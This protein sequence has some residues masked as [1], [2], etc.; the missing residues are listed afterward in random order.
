MRACLLL[1]VALAVAGTCRAGASIID[2]LRVPSGFHVA[3]YSDDVADAREM[4]LG[5]D[6]TVYVGSSRAGRIYALTDADHDGRAERVRVIASGL[7]DPIGVAFH[8]G[9][10]YASAVSRILVWRDIGQHLDQP[11][12]P[13]V[14]TGRLPDEGHHGGRFIAFGPDGKL[15]VPIGAPCNICKRK[16]YARLLRM[17]AH[18]TH[19][20][21]VAR[22]IRNTV[23]F[24]WQPGSQRLW[25]TDNGRD[26]LGDNVPSDELNRVDHVG[27]NFGYP[28]CHAGDVLDPKFGDDLSC[29][30]FAAPALKLGA[31]VAAL[32]MAFYDGSM[33]P[34]R[35]RGAAFIAEH[36]SWN[37]SKKAGYRVVAVFIDGKRVRGSEPFLTGFLDGQTTRGRPVDVLVLDDGSLLVSDD[38][39]GAIYRISTD[40]R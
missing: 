27:Q 33:F 13:Q 19:W 25:F 12:A 10:L 31:H 26:M 2:D 5:A 32:G 34:G 4:A 18:G 22:G 16:G 28:Y 14:V 6:G 24:D 20:Q 11:P 23:G 29:A 38:D 3:L 39:N 40:N 36:G 9:D 1:F 15:Y 37:R 21:D 8:D 30:K 7:R 17:D 35:Y